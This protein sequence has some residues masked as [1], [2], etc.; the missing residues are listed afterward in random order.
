MY[1]HILIPTDGS[2][3]SHK[4]VEHGL[5]LAKALGAKATLITATEP[6]PIIYGR[7]WN[8]TPEAARSF[9]EENNRSAAAIF[10]KAMARAAE[11]GLDVDKVHVQNS[12]AATAILD[13]ASELGC[14]LIVMAS[15]GRGGI[16]KLLLG[17]QTNE[18]VATSHL[19]VLVVR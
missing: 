15:H 13:K 9:E 7:T 17:S 4:G 19:P 2:D 18:V 12:A 3:V 6:F 11:F 10:D 1:S 5:A 14:D 16:T 8:P